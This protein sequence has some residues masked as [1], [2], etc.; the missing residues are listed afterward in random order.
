MYRTRLLCILTVVSSMLA[1]AASAADLGGRVVDARGSAVA[2]ATLIAT[3]G[4]HTWSADAGQDGRF[5]LRLPDPPPHP[6]RLSATAPGYQTV[7]LEVSDVGRPLVVRLTEKQVFSDTVEVTAN[8]ARPGQTPVTFTNVTRAEI[9]RSYWGQDVPMFLTQVPGFYAYNDNGN[10]VGYSYFT[11]RGFDMR[12][13]AV[14]LNGVPLNDAEEHSVYFIDL[15]DFL[16]TTEDIQVQRGVGTTLYGGDAIGGSVDILTLHPRGERRLRFSSMRGSWDTTRWNLEYDSGRSADGW[17]ASFRLSRIDSDGY[18]DQSWVKMWNYFA[19]IEH[20]GEHS[21]LQLVLFGGPE[22]THLAYDGVPRAYLDGEI[23]GDRRRDR[24]F[25]PLTYPQEIDHF[26]QPQEQLIHTLQLGENLTLQNTLFYFQGDGYYKQLKLGAWMPQYYLAPFP[27]PDGG[28]IDTTDL[29]RKRT[30]G[31]WDGGWIGQLQWRH[32]GGRGTLK[33]GMAVRLHR[34]HHYGEVIWAQLYPPDT[35]PNQRYYDY[36]VGKRSLQPFVQETWRLSDA[37]TLMGGVTWTSHRYEMS[38]DR[39][40][41]VSFT[42]SYDFLLP[43]LGLTWRPSAGWSMFANVS[44]GAREPA[45]RDIYDPQD[46]WGERA[47]LDPEKLIDYELGGERRWSTGFAKLNLYWLHFN[48]EIVWAG[49]LDDNGVP[50]NANGAVSNHRGIELEIGWSPLPRW[51]AH[52]A[53]S[54]ARNTFQRFTEYDYDG[55][56]VDHS[57]NRIAGAPD[58]LA[59]LQLTGGV[60]PVDAMLTVRYVGLF[61]LDNT[62]DLRKF[63]LLRDEPGYIHRINPS[64]TIVNL[65][66]QWH[67]AG[68]TAELIGARHASVDLRVN[69]L[70]DRLYTTFGYMDSSQPVWTPAATRSLYA[71]LTVDW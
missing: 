21:N 71:G 46:Y 52:L 65:A 23:S 63:P 12:R 16:S 50:I 67:L 60:G 20:S 68:T 28:L 26:F 29:V 48:N 64:Y 17:A 10:D 61:Y 24:R 15:A 32:G 35:P 36:E 2:G 62:Q 18:R 7:T 59:T 9:E 6:L 31:E 39:L 49:A 42:Q 44:R 13:V 25:N 11:L 51:G 58:R 40:K 53:A 56:P 22:E 66:L 5:V 70:A 4:A 33:A 41:N 47:R 37:W 69:N 34:G 8:R 38:R 45:F 55:N 19:T 1:V 54:L 3:A 57:G 30:V 27:G 43:R 14:S